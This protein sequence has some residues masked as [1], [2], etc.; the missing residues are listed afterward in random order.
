MLDDFKK[1]AFRGSVV[2][3]L[4]GFT[5]GAAFATVAKSL[6][7]DIIMPPIGLLL[8]GRDF[9]QLFWILKVGTQPPPYETLEQA[10]AVG[11]VT[12]N[13][14]RFANNVFAFLVV[15]FAI[16]LLLRGINRMPAEEQKA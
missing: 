6:V 7:D 4:I 12:L 5:V 9:T 10:H 1:F 8:G 15:A 2:D 14:G 11:A 16:Y 3:L 13:Y